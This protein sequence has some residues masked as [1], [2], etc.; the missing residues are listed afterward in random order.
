MRYNFNFKVLTNRFP[1]K[2]AGENLNNLM[3]AIKDSLDDFT[4]KLNDVYDARFITYAVGDTLDNWGNIL[5]LTRNTGESDS[6]YRARL[7]VA[8]RDIQETLTIAVLK[9]AIEATTNSEPTCREHYADIPS[10]PFLW[11]P[12]LFSYAHLLRA[13]FILG[14]LNH[15]TNPGFEDGTWAG[16]ETQSTEQKYKGDYSGK[17]VSDGSAEVFSGYSNRIDI[18]PSLYEYTVSAWTNITTFTQG[19]FVLRANFYD[20][21]DS[22]LGSMDWKEFTA[23][24][25]GWE[26]AEYTFLP[27]DFPV[28]TAKIDFQF[29]WILDGAILP[30]GTAYVDNY[31]FEIGSP[32]TEDWT[33][34]E[35]DTIASDLQDVKLAI[36]TIYLVEDSGLGYYVLKKTA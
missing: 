36:L 19:K 6:T 26:K 21:G 1:F 10:F 31:K 9:N 14:N 20:T 22:L 16:S 30:S 13:S 12:K 33:Q 8:F 3:K 7:L 23:A 18:N 4:S 34:T 25:T 17:L 11:D 28:N 32:A 2:W 29:A 27:G 15:I 5:G 35:L 24:T